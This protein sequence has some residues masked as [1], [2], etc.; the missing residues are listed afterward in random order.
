M[1]EALP[2]LAEINPG[3]WVIL[4]GLICAVLPV[5]NARKFLV[6]LAPVFAAYLIFNLHVAPE[7]LGG[8]V[9]FG[10]V[11]L[12]TLR[13]DRLSVVWGYLFCLA[14][15]INAIYG[16]H[17]KCRI[18]D[19]SA[20]V[21]TGAAIAGVLAGDMLSLFVF[22]E[23]TAISSV[24]LIWKGGDHAYRAGLRYL[25][26]HVLSGVMLLAGAVMHANANGGDFT[27]GFIG[28]DSPGG[29]LSESLHY[30]HGNPCEFHHKICRLCL[31]ARV[32]RRRYPD[33][34]WRG[35][36]LFSRLLC[37]YRKRPPSRLGLFSE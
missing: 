25:A 21:Y 27:F 24:I 9:Q 6:L 35:Y 33:L 22:W 30:G 34:D 8:I 7:V 18:T 1:I 2:W 14:G 16:L 32:S 13:I 26:I 23:L 20:L 11:E 12:T 37:R 10:P 3:L 29:C 15:V 31:G 36:D 28:L 5:G 17:E 19:S 4:A